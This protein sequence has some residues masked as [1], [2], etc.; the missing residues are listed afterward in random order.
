MS[1]QRGGVEGVV[2]LLF[3]QRAIA[4]ESV[5]HELQQALEVGLL[6]RHLGEHLKHG[7]DNFVRL[8][9]QTLQE[10]AEELNARVVQ[11]PHHFPS[12]RVEEQEDPAEGLQSRGLPL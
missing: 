9:I 1:S 4:V 11:D 10:G 6:F 12:E 3:Q 5:H 2:S 7:E 8:V